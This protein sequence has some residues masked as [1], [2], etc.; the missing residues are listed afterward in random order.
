MVTLLI[1]GCVTD[2][3]EN[4]VYCLL[5][6]VSAG[7]VAALLFFIFMKEYYMQIHDDGFDLIKGG[8][9]THY[10]FSAFAGS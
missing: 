7:L 9:T 10:D 4:A 8:K 3:D 2:I 1:S 5:A 6:A